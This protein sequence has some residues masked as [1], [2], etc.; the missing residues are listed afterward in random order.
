MKF[1]EIR[2][3]F[4]Y[5]CKRKDGHMLELA[6]DV[7]REAGRFLKQHV[8]RIQQID[9]KLGQDTNLVTEV[10]R[11]A[12]LMIVERIKKRYPHHGF[13]GE[14]FGEQ[15]QTAEYKWIIDPLDGT[16]NFTHGL[17]IFCVS[18]GLEVHGELHLG[19]V[20]DPN[21][22][23][24]FVAQKGKGAYLNNRRL[25]VSRTTRLSESLLVT[26]F[27]YDIKT[28]TDSILVHFE[29][30]LKEAQAVRRLGS[31]AL[32]LCYVAAG[33]FDGYWENALNPWDM[34]AGVLMVQE[35]GGTCT[36]L[37]GFPSTIYD[38]PVLATNGLL[39]EQM[40]EVLKRGMTSRSP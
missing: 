27:P 15:E 23:E 5:Y 2:F 40:V 24:L 30:F 21:L 11:R 1:M 33:R 12:E 39:H 17:P 14:E 35:A 26:G 28:K 31:A 4:S 22:D 18:I 29:N 13:F 37:R 34:A 7:A 38:K 25:R 3:S 32:D 6:I 36:D 8:G 19:V 16:T 10:D 20:Y 9:R